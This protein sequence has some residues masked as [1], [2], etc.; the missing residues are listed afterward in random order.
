MAAAPPPNRPCWPL[1][2]LLG[3]A[4]RMGENRLGRGEDRRA[5]RRDRVECAG[6]GKAL[7]LAPVSS[8]GSIRSAKSSSDLNGPFASRSA[9]SA[10]I[11]FS[12]TPLSAPS[13]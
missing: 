13:A 8:R 1:V 11:A 4:R 2:A 5:V 12:P 6:R 3:R 7:D 9:T 10:S